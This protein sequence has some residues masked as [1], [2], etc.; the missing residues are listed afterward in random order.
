MI[1]I[2]AIETSF[3]FLR[4]FMPMLGR[5]APESAAGSQ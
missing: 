3:R 4:L 2:K 5:E 1:L